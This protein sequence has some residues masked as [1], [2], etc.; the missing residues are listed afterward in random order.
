MIIIP[1]LTVIACIAVI[2][3]ILIGYSDYQRLKD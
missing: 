1:A 2:G 3:I